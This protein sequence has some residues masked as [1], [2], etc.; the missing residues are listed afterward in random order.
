MSTDLAL[1]NRLDALSKLLLCIRPCDIEDIHSKCRND[2]EV[3]GEL[4]RLL[5][6]AEV[7]DPEQLLEDCGFFKEDE[8]AERTPSEDPE[9]LATVA[10]VLSIGCGKQ[11]PDRGNLV[12]HCDKVYRCSD[13]QTKL[14]GIG[15][16]RLLT[17]IESQSRKLEI[18]LGI[19]KALNSR[20]QT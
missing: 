18:L 7:E 14:E 10:D 1:P 19:K 15:Y 20:L 9:L 5:N 4:V 11:L 2:S 16:V 8:P 13:C 12:V 6:E 3:I 17:I